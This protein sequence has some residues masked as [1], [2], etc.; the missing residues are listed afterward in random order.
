MNTSYIGTPLTKSNQVICLRILVLS[1]G[2]LY[3][4]RC[5]FFLILK[6]RFRKSCSNIFWKPSIQFLPIFLSFITIVQYNQEET[7]LGTM[8]VY[9]FMPLSHHIWATELFVYMYVYVYSCVYIFYMV[10]A[11]NRHLQNKVNGITAQKWQK[12][13]NTYFY[14]HII[15]FLNLKDIQLNTEKDMMRW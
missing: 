10:L 15:F 4:T 12:N 7:D 8:H 6:Y 13:L 5:F 11:E 9:S 2:I 1:Y 3:P 14:E